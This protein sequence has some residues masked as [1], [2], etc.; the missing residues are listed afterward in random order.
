MKALD[1]LSVKLETKSL[2]GEDRSDIKQPTQLKQL[3]LNE[4]SK[5][6]WIN[7]AREDFNL[8]IKDVAD[9]LDNKNY[10]TNPDGRIYGLKNAKKFLLNIG[11]K[12]ISKDELRYL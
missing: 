4:I 6:L 2:S 1:Y 3:N 12:K 5:P 10:K 8:L 11:T 7:L 9:N